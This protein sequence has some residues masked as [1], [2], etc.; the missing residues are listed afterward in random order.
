MKNGIAYHLERHRKTNWF[1]IT[2][3]ENETQVGYIHLGLETDEEPVEDTV[4]DWIGCKKVQEH[5]KYDDG[6][7]ILYRLSVAASH[8]R[9]GIGTHLMRLALLTSE[10]M[11]P[12][13]GI[14]IEAGA[15]TD[16]PDI[17]LNTLIEFYKKMGFETW[18]IG[19]RRK[20]AL[21]H[22]AMED[23]WDINRTI[24]RRRLRQ[25]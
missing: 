4:S 2:A 20:T 22:I 21:M 6:A 10:N 19:D 16:N 8:R 7:V 23:I 3:F 25:I 1:V 12:F 9:K 18:T 11:F 15:S 14:F 13:Y 17:T 5:Q 24:K